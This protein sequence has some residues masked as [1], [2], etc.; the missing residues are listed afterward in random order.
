MRKIAINC[1]EKLYTCANIKRTIW[2]MVDSK[3]YRCTFYMLT[4]VLHCHESCLHLWM[5]NET[6]MEKITVQKKK[7][8]LSAAIGFILYSNN[9]ED[10]CQPNHADAE[11]GFVEDHCAVYNSYV[12]LVKRNVLVFWG[13]RNTLSMFLS[14]SCCLSRLPIFP[15]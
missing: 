14:C 8:T 10:C 7:R 5:P 1:S 6:K 12:K 3:L 11:Q 4:I 13:T 9:V 2:K 15:V